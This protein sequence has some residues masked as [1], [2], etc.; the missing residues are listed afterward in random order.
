MKLAVVSDIHGNAE[1]FEAVLADIDISGADK[2]VCLGDVI[3]YG[4][5][6]NE[7]IKMIC[8]RKIP[9]VLGNHELCIINRE[10]LSRFNPSA[11]RSM[12]ITI[13]M[14][15]EESLR[16]VK[17]LKK[18]ILTYSSRFVHGFP[19]ES[20]TKYMFEFDKKG[21]FDAL[22]KYEERVCFIGH[23]HSL[24]LIE[25]DG[26]TIAHNV[27]DKGVTQLC[28]DK[29]YIINAGSVG[30]PRD[31]D[32]HAKYII[33]DTLNDSIEVKYISYDINSVV[34]KIIKAGLPERNARRLL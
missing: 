24:R 11:Y 6:P 26:S 14:L 28:A 29:R 22:G 8:D 20:P 4:P 7:T 18:S 19:P 21:I 12:L 27:L 10:Y 3:G 2:I 9:T 33:W 15:K 13:G 32:K 5:E 1:A 17:S 23:T 16:F 30:Q 25:I 34:N 31:G